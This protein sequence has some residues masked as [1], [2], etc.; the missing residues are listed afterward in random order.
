[1]TGRPTKKERNESI[2]SVIR[3][4]DKQ[5]HPLHLCLPEICPES[6]KRCACSISV[7]TDGVG[8]AA[9]SE[10]ASSKRGGFAL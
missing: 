10:E 1:M 4:K 9:F 5:S 7:P 6:S 8:F 3:C 2:E